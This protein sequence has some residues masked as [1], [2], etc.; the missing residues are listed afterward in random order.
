MASRV[1]LCSEPDVPTLTSKS[2]IQ[3]TSVTLQWNLRGTTVIN[4]SVV[5]YADVTSTSSWQTTSDI[6]SLTGL[7]PGHE[8]VFY[9]EVVSFDKTVRSDN[10]TVVTGQ[11]VVRH[12][13]CHYS[14]YCYHTQSTHF[15]FQLECANN[16]R[17][18]TD[19][20]AD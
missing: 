16:S 3:Q 18:I 8:Y 2:D 11:F 14:A 7:T 10:E 4:S 20:V 9:L 6:N 5:H 15:Y 12:A 17:H 13:A 1:S 19:V